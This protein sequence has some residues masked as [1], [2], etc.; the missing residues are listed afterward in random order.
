M[1]TVL[2][3]ASIFGVV[4]LFAAYA[5]I[6]TLEALDVSKLAAQVAVVLFS[7]IGGGIGAALFTPRQHVE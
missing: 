2:R 4:A 7:G 3:R 5:L 6:A 1:T